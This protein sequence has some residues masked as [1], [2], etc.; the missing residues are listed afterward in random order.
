[1][2]LVK[3]GWIPPLDFKFSYHIRGIQGAC[4][5]VSRVQNLQF[6]PAS[7]SF[8][9]FLYFF[10]LFD[11]KYRLFMPKLKISMSFFDKTSTDDRAKWARSNDILLVSGKW[12]GEKLCNKYWMGPKSHL[13]KNW[14]SSRLWWDIW[15]PKRFS[16]AIC[17]IF[18]VFWVDSVID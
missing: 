12:N 18:V 14:R 3:G 1:M 16:L 2:N 17:K 4:D 10:G 6:D 8:W 7:L 11:Q 9:G 5:T 13:S 15:Q